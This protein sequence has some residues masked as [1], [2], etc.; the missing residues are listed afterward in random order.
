MRPA[1][2]DE[3]VFVYDNSPPKVSIEDPDLEVYVDQQGISGLQLENL[4]IK[5]VWQLR[6]IKVG[7]QLHFGSFMAGII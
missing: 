5:S 7:L 2:L 1:D 3:E 6:K 4:E